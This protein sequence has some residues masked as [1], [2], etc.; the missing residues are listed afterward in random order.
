MLHSVLTNNKLTSS[1]EQINDAGTDNRPG[2]RKECPGRVPHL[3][4]DNSE[5][6]IGKDTKLSKPN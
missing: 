4:L 1:I 6:V 3:P 5:N 2:S